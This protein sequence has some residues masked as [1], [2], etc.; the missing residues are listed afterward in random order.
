MSTRLIITGAAVLFVLAAPSFGAAAPVTYNDPTGDNAGGADIGAVTADLRA[1]GKIAIELSVASMPQVGDQALVIAALDTDGN[2]ATGSICGRRLRGRVRLRGLSLDVV[3]WDGSA[4]VDTTGDVTAIVGNGSVEIQMHP[5]A[6]G[7]RPRST[8]W[9]P[10]AR[11][12]LRRVRSTS[13]RMRAPGPSRRRRPSL[14][15]RST[16]SSFLPRRA[17]VARFRPRS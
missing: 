5:D 7:G 8:S 12:I 13:H 9:S 14:S 3:R 15:R 16:R 17:P 10:S 6:I 11:E 1:D 2:A 4:Y